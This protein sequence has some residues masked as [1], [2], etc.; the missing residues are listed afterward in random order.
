MESPSKREG[1]AALLAIKLAP[2][3]TRRWLI[4]RQRLVDKFHLVRECALICVQAPEGYGKTSL[5]A[6]FRRE[7]LGAGG[8]AA[9]LA[10]DAN[11]DAG[12]FVEALLL[13]AY[14]AMGKPAPAKAVE[15][16]LRTGIEPREAIAALLGELADA[17]RPMALVLDDVH[18]LPEAVGSELL[19]YVAFNLPPNVHLI[20]GT[21]RRLP[22]PT[23]DLLAHGQFVAFDA[24]D[25][26]FR[27]DETRALLEARCGNR[28]DADAAVRLHERVEGW[29]MGLQLLLADLE[30]EPDPGASLRRV[31]AGRMDLGSFF[32]DVILPRLHP[33][34]VAFLTAVAP[35]EQLQPHLCAAV[36]GRRDCAE[37][38]ERLRN[39]T[40]TLHAAEGSEWLRLHSV[41]R[42]VLL[43]RFDAL[44]QADRAAL[45][46]RAAQWLHAAGMLERAAHH[47]LAAGR[48]ET[49]Y[50][51]IAQALYGLVTSGRAVAARDWLERLPEATVL[52]ND[53][54]RI[55]AAW[56]R[57]L[58]HE[59][60]E[61]YPLTEPLIGPDVDPALRF[62]ALQVRGAAAHHA[63]DLVAAAQVSELVG[64][65][66]PFGTPVI[67]AA[68]AVL[69]AVLALSRGDTAGARAALAKLGLPAPEG[70]DDYPNYFAEFFAGL[71]YLLDARP[72]TAAPALE[73]ALARADFAFGRRSPPACLLAAAF[74]AALWDQDK[75]D[76]AEAVLADRLDVIERTAV[77]E[78]V[79]LAYLALARVALD[80]RD[81][82]RIQDLLEGLYALGVQRRQP[83]MIVASLAEQ[84]RVQAFARRAE[85]CALAIARLREQRETWR[86][87]ERGV[88]RMVD[89]MCGMA[90]IR[91]ALC[92]ADPQA[93]NAHI[94]RLLGAGMADACPRD[95][96]ELLAL[97]WLTANIA[98]C[99]A[100]HLR[101]EVE[102]TAAAN[103]LVRLLRDLH[104][105]AAEAMRGT[106]AALQP[107]RVAAASGAVAPPVAP[108][109]AG[110][111]AVAPAG[112][113]TAKE[114][115]VLAM[116][117]RNY[118]NKEIARALDIG[119]TT[120]KWHLRNLF[121]K[122]N[123]GGRRHAVQRAR[124]LQLVGPEQSPQ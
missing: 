13:S 63:D 37:V 83:R 112:L 106:G 65:D 44:P 70:R 66:N 117:A 94:E 23:S 86:E 105:L 24:A 93:A 77:P 76:A 9:W 60:R 51:W 88:G 108:V 52:G 16:L 61:A 47:A 85:A 10:L 1:A 39:D 122:L 48:H 118:S 123:V 101:R 95:R 6:R 79:A 119:P 71:S 114:R 55:V 26:C 4:A 107:V 121:G 54:L 31:A 28:V 5:L 19:S 11:D 33:D 14:T 91:A 111:P 46:W 82:G 25:L 40:P 32:A 49:A 102:D 27:L 3:R 103:G 34:D 116:L 8:C 42:D 100:D 87:A 36:T 22:F 110:R 99:A 30:R 84:V 53:R 72:D 21:R 45:H 12:R 57:A 59:P 2:P 90:E 80:R 120:V 29:P 43:K 15:R 89:W 35:L 124:M 113:L 69:R 115:E 98:G 64:E 74:A 81:F 104:P 73:R 38:L 20:I 67:R 109:V 41:S 68:N 92:T 18:A 78:A 50:Q 75:P 17:A 62:E 96:L 7:W 56:M 97:R 58:S